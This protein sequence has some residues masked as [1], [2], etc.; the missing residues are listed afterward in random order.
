MCLPASATNHGD[1]SAR[2]SE[3]FRSLGATS[4]TGAHAHCGRTLVQ[5]RASRAR[6]DKNSVLGTYTYRQI[7]YINTHIYTQTKKP[8]AS[9]S[10]DTSWRQAPLLD[11]QDLSQ[12]P[13]IC[14]DFMEILR[15]TL[16]DICGVVCQRKR[17][18][19]ESASPRTKI[20]S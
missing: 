19:R 13:A 2:V 16:I 8:S 1:A 20:H 9:R 18:L 5:G 10:R 17:G 3:N 7:T 6:T 4:A 12:N 15:V 14:V 11:D